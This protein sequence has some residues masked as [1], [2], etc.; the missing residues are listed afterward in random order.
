MYVGKTG[1][2]DHDM[3]EEIAHLVNTI[4]G[5]SHL[6]HHHLSAHQ[7]LDAVSVTTPIIYMNTECTSQFRY[8]TPPTSSL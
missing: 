2:G 4:V 1:G 6:H 8:Y 7:S 3:R 5:K